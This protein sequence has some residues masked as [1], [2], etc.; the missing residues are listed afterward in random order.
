MDN[1]GEIYQ[2][3]LGVAIPIISYFVK[4]TLDDMKKFKEIS[5][6]TQKDL[7]VLK[8]D[9]INKY[10]RLEEKF[11]DLFA[12]VKDLT[13]EIKSLNTQLSKKKDI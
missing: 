10:T 13:Q 9:H 2:Y 6:N 1:L 12:A 11:D 8:T 7:E 5:Y 4:R 3:L